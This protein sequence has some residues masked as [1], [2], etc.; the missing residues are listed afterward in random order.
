[1]KSFNYWKRQEVSEEFG[2]KEVKKHTLLEQWLSIKCDIPKQT[3]GQLKQLQN[4]LKDNVD[5]WNEMELKMK[6]L[7][8]LMNLVDYDT[9]YYRAFMERQLVLRKGDETINGTVD[10]LIAKGTQIPCS[11]FFSIHVEPFGEIPNIGEYKP[12]ATASKDPLGQL[13][14]AMVAIYK[15]NQNAGLEF[16]LYGAYV[17]GQLFYFVVFDGKTYCKSSPYLATKDEIFDIFCILSEVK[18]YIDRLI[19]KEKLVEV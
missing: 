6:F 10:F 9:E 2:I 17:V 15:D 3:K 5:L 8:P 7:G 16:P 13:L 1:M 18:V 14:I 11:P 4:L 19:E 12:D